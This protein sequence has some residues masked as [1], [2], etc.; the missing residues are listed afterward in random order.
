M[1]EERENKAQLTNGIL[2]DAILSAVNYGAKTIHFSGGGEPLLHPDIKEAMKTAKQYGIKIALSTN[3]ILLNEEIASLV[4]YPRVSLDAVDEESYEII[5]GSK[6]FDNVIYNIQHLSY[7][8]KNKLG[9]G[10]VINKYNYERIYE[11]AQIGHSLGVKF[12]HIR[13]EF[14]R[15]EADNKMLQVHRDFFKERIAMAKD[16][17]GDKIEIYLSLDKFDG[18][19]TPR[20]YNKCRATPLI[21]VLKANG[22]FIP[23]QDRLDLEFGNLNED[24]FYTIWNSDRHRNVIEGINLDECP[25][26]VETKKNEYIQKLFIEDGF[27]RDML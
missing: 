25:R 16:I 20:C 1:K 8:S 21:A 14:T 24:T 5:K 13:P 23:C 15:D 10:F 11:F 26:C 22:E 4:D 3:G 12:V 17:F 18:Y 27:L 6:Q 9:L 19:W 2:S 7:E